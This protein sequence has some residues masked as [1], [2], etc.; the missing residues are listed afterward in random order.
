VPGPS[1]TTATNMAAAVVAGTRAAIAAAPDAGTAGATPAEAHTR[2]TA[3][4]S[5]AGTDPAR[6][7][8]QRSTG[9]VALSRARRLSALIAGVGT[10]MTTRTEIARTACRPAKQRA[11]ERGEAGCRLRIGA[12]DG[13][14]EQSAADQ[15]KRGAP[16]RSHHSIDCMGRRVLGASRAGARAAGTAEVMPSIC[17]SHARAAEIAAR[18]CV[19]D[20]LECRRLGSV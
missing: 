13:S 10:N 8:A 20:L 2:G 16:E 4:L 11:Q 14:T 9:S 19:E 1:F 6:D 15:T 17:A 7:P 3:A 5:G 12:L 18:R